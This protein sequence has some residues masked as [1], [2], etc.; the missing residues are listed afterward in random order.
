MKLILSK[1]WFNL[2]LDLNLKLANY[3]YHYQLKNNLILNLNIN[4][5]ELQ[6]L[7]LPNKI[8][9]HNQNNLH[10]LRHLYSILY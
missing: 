7:E 2:H 3:L 10:L 1:I 6:V 4:L 5:N 8:H 9:Y